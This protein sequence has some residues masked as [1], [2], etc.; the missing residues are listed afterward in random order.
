MEQ[1]EHEQS[2]KP[3]RELVFSAVA[4]ARRQIANLVDGLDDAELA[5][6]SLCA[7]WDIKTVAAHLLSTL[8]DDLSSF[9][10]LAALRGSL[11]RAI[12]ELARRRAHLPAA[13]ITACLRRCA[14]RPI[15]PPLFGPLDPLADV[16]VHSG[17]IRIPLGMPFE[18][19]PEL[20]ALALD[21]LTGPWPFGFV[22]LGRLTGI[23]LHSNDIDRVWGKG[24]EL[25][26]P[27][28]ALMMAVAGRTA[29]HDKLDGPGLPMLLQR[30]S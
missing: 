29:L 21:F 26:G 5:T 1:R 25:R 30:L 4:D 6:P 9:L 11:A 22:P 23:A 20:A 17:D 3:E 8:D 10:R 15:S 14:D 27:A 28:A 13:E 16:L 24:S 12:D 7:G 19:D 2:M 18:P